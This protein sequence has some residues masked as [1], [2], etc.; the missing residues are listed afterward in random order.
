MPM[1]YE[2]FVTGVKHKVSCLGWFGEQIDGTGLV[3]G[4]PK[5]HLWF[6]YVAV[7]VSDFGEA[8]EVI[9]DFHSVDQR[10]EV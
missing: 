4:F 1:A 3:A 6:K 7:S 10:A 5:A 8:A 2:P 9:R